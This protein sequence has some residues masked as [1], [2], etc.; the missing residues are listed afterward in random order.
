MYQ[1]INMNTEN[2]SQGFTFKGAFSFTGLVI[3]TIGILLIVTGAQIG[4]SYTLLLIISGVISLIPGTVLLLSA[5]GVL[6][7]YNNKQLMPYTDYFIFKTGKWHL[8]SDYNRIILKYTYESQ[9]MNSKC[10]STDYISKSFDVLLISENK[11]SIMLNEF[12]DYEKA[13]LFLQK[14]AEQLKMEAVDYYEI[15]KE[16]IAYRKQFVRR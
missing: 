3:I 4:E 10:N 12:A 14:Y 5:R 16:R 11:Q 2:I 1:I 13:K 6:I 15:M 9:I 7:D 8:L